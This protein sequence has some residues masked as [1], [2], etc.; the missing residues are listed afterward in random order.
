MR[1]ADLQLWESQVVQILKG[2][3]GPVELK[4]KPT[5]PGSLILDACDLEDYTCSSYLDDLDR[6]RQLIME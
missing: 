6:H 1:E 4:Q 2:E 5:T 3:E